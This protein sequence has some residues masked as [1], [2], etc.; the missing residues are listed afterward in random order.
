M[1]IVLEGG[2]RD[3]ERHDIPAGLFQYVF[4]VIPDPLSANP[5]MRAEVYTRTCKIRPHDDQ[6]WSW[7]FTFSSCE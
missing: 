1:K 2:L 6:T 5:S 7:V 3:G 4:P